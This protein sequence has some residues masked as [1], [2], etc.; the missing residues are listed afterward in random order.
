[1]STIQRLSYS[2]LFCFD[3]EVPTQTFTEQNLEEIKE[4]ELAGGGGTEFDCCFDY[5][6]EEGIVSN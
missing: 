5:M 4:Y 2:S 3:T 6:K 1:M